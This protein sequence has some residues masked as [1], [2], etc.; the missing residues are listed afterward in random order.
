MA[1][2]KHAQIRYQALD[3]CFSNFGRMFDINDLVEECNKA[4]YNYT[5]INEGVKKRQVYQDIIFMESSQGWSVELKRNKNGRRVFFRYV[6]INFS[7]NS[8]P[9]NQKEQHQI[10]QVL[11]TL[12]RFRGLPQFEWVEDITGRFQSF[13]RSGLPLAARVMDF[14]QNHFLAGLRY[15]PEIFDAI[16][17]K[18]ALQI[19]YA[20]FKAGAPLIFVFHPYYIKQYNLRWFIFGLTTPAA[21]I[22]NLALDRIVSVQAVPT[23]YVENTEIDFVNYFEDVVGVTIPKGAICEKIVLLITAERWPYVMTKPIHDSQKVIYHANDGVQIELDVIINPELIAKILSYGAD[24][25]VITPTHLVQMIGKQIQLL[26]EYY[27][28]DSKNKN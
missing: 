15:M 4:I 3:K 1:T 13:T 24:I 26:F 9:L 5:G 19:T 16:V 22:T 17:N 28:A 7:I 23:P 6:D 25:K 2:N 21:K 11:L 14:E 27:K 20:P 10:E 18:Q 8:T 12:S